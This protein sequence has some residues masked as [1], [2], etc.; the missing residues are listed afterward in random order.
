M[1]GF[2]IARS[3]R[4]IMILLLMVAAVT[5]ADDPILVL[6]PALAGRM[7]VSPI[8]S[9]WFIA[10]LGAGSVFGSLRRSKHLPSMR[11]AATALALLGGCMVA[12]VMAPW[13]WVGVIAA[14]GAG[15][16]CLVANAATRTLLSKA[17]GPERFAAV[18][19]VWAIAWAGSK[20]FASLADGL[21]AGWV[22]L[23]WTGVILAV[24]ALIPV[25]VLLFMPKPRAQAGGLPPQPATAHVTEN[26]RSSPD[27]AA[28]TSQSSRAIGAHFH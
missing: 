16:S 3:D 20:P 23:R 13:I 8:W 25:I 4:M 18:M 2:R 22:G 19:A 6:G 5:V 7:H 14:F 12:F 28:E 1:E 27:T 24:P 26:A 10:A 11:L 17:A 9:G 15:I 21:L